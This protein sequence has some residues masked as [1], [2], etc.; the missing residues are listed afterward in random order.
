MKKILVGYDG[1]KVAKRALEIALK[2]AISFR[3]EV[4][5]VTSLVGGADEP[6]E[7]IK[8]AENDLVYAQ[9]FFDEN[10]VP[11]VTTLL[12]RGATPGE[13]LVRYAE[14]N[15][16]DEIVIGIKRKSKVGK[17]L[18]GSNAQKIILDAKCPVV[19]VK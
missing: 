1:S 14:D 4:S 13:D 16:I 18:F 5:V 11:C 7:D 3:A 10:K 9:S 12:V 19:T 15:E 6:N 8:G 17:M 2:H